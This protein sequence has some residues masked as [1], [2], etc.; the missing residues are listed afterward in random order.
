MLSTW[1][2]HPVGHM[3]PSLSFSPFCDSAEVRETLSEFRETPAAEVS[4]VL[5]T[6]P[7]VVCGQREGRGQLEASPVT[8]SHVFMWH[9]SGDTH[10]QQKKKKTYSIQP[11]HIR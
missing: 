8:G 4:A 5:V 1:E 3:S 6:V 10:L 7:C 11:P 9:S 2:H